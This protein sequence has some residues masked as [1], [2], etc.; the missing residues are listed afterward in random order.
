MAD[1]DD[2]GLADIL[3][4]GPRV[5]VLRGLPRGGFAVEPLLLPD[6]DRGA[7]GILDAD[8]DGDLDVVLA[9]R[10]EPPTFLRNET[11]RTRGS[12]RLRLRGVPDRVEGRTWSNFRGLGAD[13]EVKAGDLLARRV[14][15]AGSGFPGQA[16]DVVHVGLGGRARADFVRV[17]WPDGVLQ[18]EHEVAAGKVHEIVEVN[19][20]IA[21]CPVIFA[22][23]GAT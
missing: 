4:V 11:S 1:L 20:K 6:A 10:G 5:T 9:A 21:S 12:L 13:V 23:D 8:G 16:S 15:A 14:V 18:S 2:D 22:W 17:R 3:A 7:I 19:R